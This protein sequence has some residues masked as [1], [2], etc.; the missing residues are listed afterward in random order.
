MADSTNFQYLRGDDFEAILD[1]LEDSGEVEEQCA[2]IVR[3]VSWKRGNSESKSRI[4]VLKFAMYSLHDSCKQTKS[5]KR[6]RKY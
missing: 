1:I 3:N 6:S 5:N 4:T 2:V